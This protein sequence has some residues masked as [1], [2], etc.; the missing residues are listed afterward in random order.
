M[1]AKG[2]IF[3][4]TSISL[5]LAAFRPL[6]EIGELARYKVILD[7]S[8]YLRIV[9]ETNINCFYCDHVGKL[10]TDTLFVQANAF[11]NYHQIKNSELRVRTAQFKCGLRQMT[12]D[13]MDLLDEQNH[14]FLKVKVLSLLQMDELVEA[15]TLIYIAGTGVKYKV[16]STLDKQTNFTACKGSLDL[17]I[18]DF[19]IEPPTKLF[20]AVRVKETITIEF[21]LKLRII[22][23]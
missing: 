22:E 2:I 1:N 13:M 5:G 10:P 20:G 18:R 23:E 7:E 14:P 11:G 9:G 12:Q 15:T 21:D 17:N 8:S 16:R 3:F 6:N 19:G 4:L